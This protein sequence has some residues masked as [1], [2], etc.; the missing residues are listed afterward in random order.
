MITIINNDD[1]RL[2]D[3]QNSHG[4]AKEFLRKLSIIW[5]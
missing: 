2:Q 4:H 1:A 3:P 5:A